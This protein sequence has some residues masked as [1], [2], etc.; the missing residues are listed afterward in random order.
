MSADK[1]ALTEGKLCP[2]MRRLPNV[3]GQPG[4]RGAGGRGRD[5]A[6]GPGRRARSACAGA[7]VGQAGVLT[8]HDGRVHAHAQVRG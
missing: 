4:D 7:D 8:S 5:C 6:Q 1:A 2:A 3:V